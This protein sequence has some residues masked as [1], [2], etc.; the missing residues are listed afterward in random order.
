[1]NLDELKSLWQCQKFDTPANP[2]PGEQ[3]KLMRIKLKH[4]KRATLW[5]DAMI[6]VASA[7]LILF[8]ARTM[9][10]TPLLV[11]RIGLVITIASLVFWIWEPI[12]ARRAS[13]QPQADA[14]VTQW[15][16]YELEKVRVQSAL[17]RGRLWSVL[18]FWIGAVVFTWGLDTSLSSRIFFSTVLTGMNLA[19][20]VTMWKFN[21]HA[22]R[23]ADR[24]L[25]EELESLLKSNSPG[26]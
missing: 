23:K 5:V 26:C 3:I 13:P 21:Q 16:R 11:A 12:R 9:L 14:P 1:M 25:I 18:P 4:L 22:W 24:P 10:T 17:K 19:I 2:S 8:F 6:I 7:L 15:L 20:Y